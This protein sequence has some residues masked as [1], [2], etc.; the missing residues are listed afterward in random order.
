[1]TR[2]QYEQHKQRL[3]EQLQAG[4]RLLESAHQ[5]QIRALDVVWM[6]QAEAPATAPVAEAAVGSS[7]EP[8]PLPA[9]APSP[10][11]RRTPGDLEHDLR[12]T[13]PRLPEKF[14]RGDVR[15][16]LGY[17][18]DRGTLYRILQGLVRNGSL[19]IEDVGSGRR[20]TVYRKTGG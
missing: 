4:I 9:P 16:A 6:L 3:D 17:E 5:A 12:E 11:R 10:P 2:E 18:P 13:L 20:A 7:P 14:T 1:M 15:E 8:A 19:H